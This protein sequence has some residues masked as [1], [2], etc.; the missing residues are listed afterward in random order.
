MKDKSF[1]QTRALQPTISL[2]IFK[3]KEEEKKE[4]EEEEKNKEEEEKDEEEKK[5]L[6]V[7]L[8]KGF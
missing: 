4:G 7:L 8:F 1:F 5:S 2:N 6:A 3:T